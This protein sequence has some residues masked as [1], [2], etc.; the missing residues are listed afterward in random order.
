MTDTGAPP[1]REGADAGSHVRGGAGAV[2]PVL[3]RPGRPRDSRADEAILDAAL[4]VLAEVGPARFTV[5]EVAAR[6]GCGK[7][8]IY[9]RWP[10]RGALLLDTGHHRMGLHIADPD[11]GTVRGDLIAIMGGLV[12][13]MR[14]TAAGK[15]MPAVVAEAAVNPEMRAVLA[16]FLHDRR[17]TGVTAVVRGVERGEL[18]E[19]T[20]VELVLDLLGG[21]VFFRV[22]MADNAP[23]ADV[24]ALVVD[25]VLN[26]IQSTVPGSAPS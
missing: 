4:E 12:R 3:R 2:P 25:A 15:I 14:D 22:L 20:D 9:R 17:A 7:A 11:T 1:I 6:A 10:S 21:F 24:V 13:K 23:D 5:D 26:G 19:G 8:T 18:P 16:G